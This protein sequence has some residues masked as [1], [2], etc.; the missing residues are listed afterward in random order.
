MALKIA[1]IGW[2][3]AHILFAAHLIIQQGVNPREIVI[4]DPYHDGGALQR[5]WTTV[6]SNTTYQQFLNAVEQVG[7][8]LPST[9]KQLYLPDEQTPLYKLC[10]IL[11]T[12]IKPHIYYCE[13]IYGYVD[14]LH[15][16]DNKWQ[17]HLANLQIVSAVDICSL[18]PGANPRVLQTGTPQ[19][20]LSAALNSDILKTYLS[21][22]NHIALFGSAHSA[23]LI[24]QN[25]AQL[26]C[27]I[28]MIYLGEKPFFYASE[29]AY[30]G[31]KHEAEQI[32]KQISADGIGGAVRLINYAETLEVHN[33]LLKADYTIC[34]CG[35]DTSN[36]PKVYVNKELINTNKGLVYNPA[37]GEI[38]PRL[39]G[40][41]ICFPSTSL[42]DGKSYVDVSIPAFA[43]HITA[44]T[45]QISCLLS[46]RLE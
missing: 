35:F 13:K 22:N 34:A 44:Q 31:V 21:S 11:H 45:P 46:V 30:G 29:G 28:S 38:V 32:A 17:I 40:W 24:A 25:L 14:S 9:T 36:V 37:N 18:A 1:L 20:P 6:R 4:I 2:G 43:A 33:A 39:Y 15:L 42:I 5:S 8:Q 16:E 3:V 27:S 12:A 26:K 10:Q 19:I 41:G 23:T 7:L